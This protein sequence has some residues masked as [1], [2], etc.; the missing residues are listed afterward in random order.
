MEALEHL[1]GTNMPPSFRFRDKE[2]QAI[3]RFIHDCLKMDKK[4]FRFLMVTGSPG[5]GKTLC[6]NSV[7]NKVECKVIRLNANMV[8]TIAEVQ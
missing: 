6:L 5:A 8:K 2:T 4:G 7:L 1:S 3:Q